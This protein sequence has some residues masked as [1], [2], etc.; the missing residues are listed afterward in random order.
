MTTTITVQAA[1]H[2]VLITHADAAAFRTERLEP[3]ATTTVHIWQGKGLTICED[4]PNAREILT[5]GLAPIQA[6]QETARPVAELGATLEAGEALAAKDLPAG[7]Q[8]VAL[9]QLRE[10]VEHVEIV[11]PFCAPTLTIAVVRLVNG[12]TLVGKS[13]C[14]DPAA[15]DAEKGERFAVDDALRQL[16]PLEAYVL[17]E[18]LD[19]EAKFGSIEKAA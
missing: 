2:P 3:H 11:R 18:K 5:A 16:W 15:F 7:A 13:A 12:F 1:D 10:K 6:Q 4:Q 17:R 19:F 14:A 9:H 8:R